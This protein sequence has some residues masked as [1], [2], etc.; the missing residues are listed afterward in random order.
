[1]KKLL[2]LTAMLFIVGVVSVQAAGSFPQ[3]T[4]CDRDCWSARDPQGAISQMS[5]LDRA[6]V[7]HTAGAADYEVTNIEE[8]KSRVRAIQ[9][10]HMDSRGWSDIG[11]H[12][13][14]DKLGNNFE[15]R[16]GSMS[17]LPRG[18]HDTRVRRARSGCTWRRRA[19]PW[20]S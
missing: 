7:H 15:G 1:M 6:V 5:G 14:T 10:Y 11:Y 19:C 20:G 13:L 16:E 4:I 3:P 12:F 2:Y 17:T 18:A 9:N 8:S